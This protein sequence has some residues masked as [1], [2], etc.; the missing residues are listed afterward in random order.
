LQINGVPIDLLDT[1]TDSI[2]ALDPEMNI[3]YANPSQ[4]TLWNLDRR[5]ILGKIFTK[6]SQ[7]FQKKFLMI[8]CLRRFPETK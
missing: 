8:R 1:L 6:L 2:I 5:E 4:A 7:S 3:I